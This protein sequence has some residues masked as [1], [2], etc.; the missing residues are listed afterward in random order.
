[1]A[2]ALVPIAWQ[3]LGSTTTTVTFSSIPSTYR[4]LYF[5]MTVNG[6][7][8]SASYMLTRMN[9]DSGTNYSD[10]VAFGSSSAGATSRN[11]A[12]YLFLDESFVT[13][14]STTYATY[15]YHI[16]D[17]ATVDKFK[18]ILARAD[19]GSNGT[20]MCAGRWSST[21]A[22]TSVTFNDGSGWGFGAG[23]TFALY[24]V[25]A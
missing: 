4:D 7:N 3:S 11:A 10:Q 1:M 9:G 14:N 2:T 17:Y 23:S 12:N 5:R 19:N 8:A 24:G 25:L 16:L 13:F 18:P 20:T 6:G 21:A 15:G 22:V